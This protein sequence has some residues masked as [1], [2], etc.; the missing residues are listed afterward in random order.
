MLAVPPI[1]ETWLALLGLVVPKRPGRIMFCWD[2]APTAI[3]APGGTGAGAGAGMPL[4]EI[5]IAVGVLVP[6]PV[7]CSVSGCVCAGE[8][9]A[10][11]T[12]P[13]VRYTF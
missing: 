2:G 6:I 5:G 3:P 12:T 7:G 4:V 11:D 9:K 10:V 1:S 8:G 13:R